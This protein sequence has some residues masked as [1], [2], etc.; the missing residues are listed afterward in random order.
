MPQFCTAKLSGFYRMYSNQLN[1][2]INT[3]TLAEAGQPV[4]GINHSEYPCVS[5]D[6]LGNIHPLWKMLPFCIW[7][8]FTINRVFQGG[9]FENKF[10]HTPFVIPRA[11]RT[12]R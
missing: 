2:R 12:K 4:R 9:R 1:N 6:R 10:S 7:T 3:G 5:A 11:N 8:C